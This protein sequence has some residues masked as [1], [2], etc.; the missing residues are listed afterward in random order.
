MLR[1]GQVPTIA[2]T[3]LGQVLAA[4][5]FA[6]WKHRN[7]KRKGVNPKNVPYI[8]HPL[9]L[10]NM[11]VNIGG[12]DDSVV[13]VAALL[14]DTVEDTET[15]FEEL[16]TA[17][18]ERVAHVVAEVTDDKSLSVGERKRRQIQH[19]GKISDDAK[20]VK[21]VDKTN[22]L[23]DLL[24]NPPPSWEPWQVRGSVAWSWLLLNQTRGINAALEKYWEDV[25]KKPEIL[26]MGLDLSVEGLQPVVDEYIAKLEAKTSSQ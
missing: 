3:T 19:T 20:L 14:H 8:Q 11:L 24:A 9:G 22:N 1:A 5:E 17:F 12:I 18:G 25:Y 13:L 4:A 10:A 23:L 21:I 2:P 16:T 7:Q 15:T 6:A 26:A